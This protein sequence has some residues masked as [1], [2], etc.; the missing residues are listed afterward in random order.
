MCLCA[1]WPWWPA[2]LWAASADLP[3]SYKIKMVRCICSGPF[4]MC[5]AAMEEHTINCKRSCCKMRRLYKTT[6]FREKGPHTGRPFFVGI[7]PFFQ[8]CGLP[9]QRPGAASLAPRG[10]IH[11]LCALARNDKLV[12]NV[13]LATALF[14]WIS[15]C[16]PLQSHR[17]GRP[18]PGP[19]DHRPAPGAGGPHQYRQ[20]SNGTPAAQT[21][22][23]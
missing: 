4:F 5:C 19:S 6:P 21:P 20:S 10:A 2:L 8:E 23:R 12:Q 17:C 7:R 3:S 9:R 1:S 13:N 22:L 11:L 18:V 16:G 15:L 14:I